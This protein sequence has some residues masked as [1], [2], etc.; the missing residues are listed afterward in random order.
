[1][2]G[3]FTRVLSAFLVA[4]TLIVPS[5][6]IMAAEGNAAEL[7]QSAL[8]YRDFYHYNIAYFKV[9][10]M[11][12]TSEKYT[13]LG[14]LASIQSVVWTDEINKTLQMLTD[15]TTTSS[16]KT[17]DKIEQ[18]VKSSSLGEWDKGYLLGELTSW[19][20]KLVWT[21]DYTKAMDALINAGI[22]TTEDKLANAEKM[23]QSIL[24]ES[25]KEYLLE[26]HKIVKNNFEISRSNVVKQI[27][28]LKNDTAL[29][30]DE[31]V[32][33]M[34]GIVRSN[35]G[36]EIPEEYFTS[37]N[38]YSITD[39]IL[40]WNIKENMEPAELQQNINNIIA[41][42]ES[43]KLKLW[44]ANEIS[45]VNSNTGAKDI[46]VTALL[47]ETLSEKLL[48]ETQI[49]F[50]EAG[51]RR[52]VNAPLV[53]SEYFYIKDGQ[54][55]MTKKSAPQEGYKDSISVKVSFKNGSTNTS[56]WIKVTPVPVVVEPVKSEQS[57]KQQAE[58]GI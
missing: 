17:Y 23:I 42:Y 50:T 7:V 2:K 45:A 44:F 10:E 9:L 56:L 46:N 47:S 34:I 38:M 18:Y 4:A 32:V 13:L 25:N 26:Q 31:K 55:F 19:G 27:L 24:N 40:G 15:L 48:P 12:E 58:A 14:N 51:W 20:K 29:D 52:G 53:P 39:T 5:A 3:R 41:K 11:P 36:I 35:K 33:K 57:G 21:E 6:K 43:T 1:M 22:E 8:S 28:N 49:E 30:R 16:A 37:A 54:V